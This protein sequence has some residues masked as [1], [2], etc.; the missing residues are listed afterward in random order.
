MLKR[1]NWTKNLTIWSVLITVLLNRLSTLITLFPALIISLFVN[2][3]LTPTLLKF[4]I[5]YQKNPRICFFVFLVVLLIKLVVAP[6]SSKGFIILIMLIHIFISYYWNSR[7]ACCYCFLSKYLFLNTRIC[8]SAAVK[9]NDNNKILV[10]GTAIFS[11][12]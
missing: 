5:I 7:S 11:T 4:L 2:I 3:F 9:T 10:R 6:K 12:S 8:C 1:F